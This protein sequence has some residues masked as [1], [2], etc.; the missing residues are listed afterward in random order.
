[1]LTVSTLPLS[2]YDGTYVNPPLS[3]YTCIVGEDNIRTRL[4]DMLNYE[5]MQENGHL[6]LSIQPTNH[7]DGMYLLSVL[8]SYTTHC[9]LQIE[10][11]LPLH[12]SSFLYD[13]DN[14]HF[15]GQC[16]RLNS[17]YGENYQAFYYYKS[18]FASEFFPFCILTSRHALLISTS[19][20]KAL[21]LMMII[22][23]PICMKCLMC[24]RN[25][26]ILFF[27][28]TAQYIPI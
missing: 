21:F 27:V 23:S 5:L 3:D 2:I 11:L 16:L 26:V 25:A 15:A 17:L 7:F 18:E 4:Q 22:P 24:L 13:S 14:V 12:D 20:Q 6:R 10:Q 19:F 1:M 28:P 9:N 8:S